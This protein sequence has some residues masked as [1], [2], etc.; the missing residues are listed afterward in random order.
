MKVLS[1]ELEPNKGDVTIPNK[2]RLSVLEQN[3]EKYNDYTVL[4]TVLM[5]HKRL[6]EIMDEREM[7]FSKTD[8]TEEELK[9]LEGLE[10]ELEQDNSSDE[11]T[12]ENQNHKKRYDGKGKRHFGK[13]KKRNNNS[14]EK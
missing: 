2:E 1:G 3:Q 7:Y 11:E 12:G 6:V 4:K 9:E 5:G 8:F 10:D 13:N 14:S